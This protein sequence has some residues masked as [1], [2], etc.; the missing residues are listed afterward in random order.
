MAHLLFLSSCSEPWGGSEEL[1]AGTARRLCRDGYRVSAC[2][3]IVDH[4][5]PRIKELRDLGIVVE[6]YWALPHLKS[7]ARSIPKVLQRAPAFTFRSML[8]RVSAR[9]AKALGGAAG[10]DGKADGRDKSVVSGTDFWKHLLL[11]SYQHVFLQRLRVISPS[12]A[13]ISQGE[14]ID[15]LHYV[16]AC[17]RVGIPYVL[18]CQKAAD[19]DWPADAL[20]G[21]MQRAFLE[22]KRVYFVSNHNRVLTER[23][24]AHRLSNAEVVRNPF[25]TNVEE[26]LPYP[27][28]DT[29]GFRLACVARLFL[30]DKGQDNLLVVLA[31]EKWKQ[32]NLK[33]SF[34]G[35]GINRE[36]LQRA[37]EMLCL[38]NVSFC[39]F[40]PDITDVWRHHH[41]L[42]L[43]SRAE[44][45]P[46]ALVEAMMCGRPGIVTNAGG[47][48]EV[49][50]DEMT[51]FL[52]RGTDAA[53]LEDVLERAW[54][55]RDEWKN[56]GLEAAK[57]IR[58]L[59]P[60]DPCG[61]FAIKIINVLTEIGK[62]HPCE[63]LQC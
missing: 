55:R 39:G 60:S 3:T 46:L 27:E 14:N 62:T 63:R 57:S 7:F 17:R 20:R 34:Y 37:S 26:A 10:S 30:R 33:V 4:T 9:Q 18:I 1:W 59:V 5:H 11:H 22:A 56:I 45:L 48:A 12:L 53:S 2:K 49:I 38:K 51:G 8:S 24:L 61:E 42:I 15:G 36:A 6:D 43:P 41:A 32:R 58:T 13:I 29:D 28:T 52:A 54:N 16:E 23:Q 44:G 50:E 31:E 35:Q 21:A 47:N 25:M 40:T 19:A